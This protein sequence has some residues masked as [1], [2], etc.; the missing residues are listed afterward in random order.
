MA[1]DE[2]A[3]LKNDET[4]SDKGRLLEYLDSIRQVWE[5]G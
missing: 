4:E 3:S 2:T 1:W 5:T